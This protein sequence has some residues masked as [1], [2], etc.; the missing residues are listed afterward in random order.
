MKHF[1]I[2]IFIIAVAGEVFAQEHHPSAAIT[3]VFQITPAFVNQLADE[4][5]TNNPGLRAAG[6][7]VNAA[8]EGEKAVRTWEDPMARFGVMAA[9]EAMRADDGDLLYGVEQRLPLFGKAKAARTVAKAETAVEQAD[10]ENRFQQLRK[11]IAQGVFRAGLADRQVELGKQDVGWLETMLAVAEQRYEIGEASQTD[12]L[13]LQNERAKRLNDIKTDERNA[14][15]ER[16]NINKLMGRD[17]HVAWPLLQ[18]PAIAGPVVYNPRLVKLAVQNDPKLKVLAQEVKRAEAMTGQARRQRYPD[19]NAG[20]E[21]RNYSGSGE[22]RQSMFTLSFSIPWGN[23]KKYD[24]DIKREEF[25][26]KAAGFEAVD[27]ERIVRDEVFH[28]TIQ[29]DAARREALLYRDEIIP[30]TEGSLETA[31]IAWESNR[32]TFRDLIDTR[33]MLLDAQLMYARAVAEQYGMMSEL[34]LC[35]G[36]GDFESLQMIGAGP[37]VEP[38]K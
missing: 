6:A 27:Y 20:V 14:E 37:E 35:C 31:R 12:I 22:F 36:L 9:N 32:G 26:T 13:R 23:R 30:R 5:R 1:I 4:A 38:K 28:L 3:N 7:R 33:R 8:Q 34:I 10:S 17:L 18:L 2:P 19:F 21:A 16:V 15:H 29:I 11:E 24:A 25:K